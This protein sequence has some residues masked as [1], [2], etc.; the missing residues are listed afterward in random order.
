[1]VITFQNQVIAAAQNLRPQ[2]PRNPLKVVQPTFDGKP[3]KARGFLVSLN[4]YCGLRS[5]DFPDDT[6]FIAWALQCMEGTAVNPWRNTMLNQRATALEQGS[7]LPHKLSHWAIFVVE[8][9]AKFLDPNEIENAG[10]S[11]DLLAQTRSARDFTN[12]F[13]RLAEMAGLT[14]EHFLLDKYRR[15]LKPRVQ[16]KL[17]RQNFGTLEQLQHAAIEWDDILFQFE[18]QKKEATGSKPRTSNYT[19]TQQRP[20]AQQTTHQPMELDYTKLTPEEQER[21]KKAGLCYKCGKPGMA[22]ECPKHPQKSSPQTGGN[23]PQNQG[24]RP[25]KIA[26][27]SRP[28]SPESEI[29]FATAQEGETTPKGFSED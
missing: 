3:E 1:V 7:P 24:Y 25:G 12:E 4:T 8:F 26:N 15:S 28:D 27:I 6:T 22:R 23:R 10:R 20:T 16:E 2:A 17:L 14:G 11:L 29:S 13:N 5:M 9:E 18:K 19:R 21:R